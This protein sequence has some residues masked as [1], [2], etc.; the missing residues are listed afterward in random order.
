M[1]KINIIYVVD[2][3]KIYQFTMKL[4]LK[5]LGFQNEIKPFF[6]GKEVL[7]AIK[8]CMTDEKALPDIIF[9]DIN[10]P[11]M[12]GF[13]FLAEFAKIKNELAKKIVIHMVSSSVDE[14]DVEKSEK[15]EDIASYIRKP[16]AVDVLAS[17]LKRFE[18]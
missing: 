16:I 4:T 15:N 13:E 5:T 1:E 10:M 6:N 7:N 18:I 9:L 8:D 14:E 17:I 11:L 12:N 3:D 2:D